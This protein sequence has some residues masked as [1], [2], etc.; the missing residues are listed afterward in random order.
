M[1]ILTLDIETGPNTAYV[2]H[3]F[4]DY[5]SLDKLQSST[6]MLTWSAKFLG[7]KEVHYREI[8]DPSFLLDLYLL[9]EEADAVVTF[10][11][12]NFD[13]KHINR[14]FVEAGFKPV[15]PCASID[16]YKAVKQNFKFP[17]NKLDY[18]AQ[19]LLGIRKL[20]T[21]GM[22]LWTA[23]LDGCPKARNKMRR[24]NIRDV[25]ITERLYRKLRPWIKN[26][27]YSADFEVDFGDTKHTCPV[28][29]SKTATE[30]RPRRTRC[31]AI[32][33]MNCNSC[34]HWFDGARRK[35]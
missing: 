4:G 30:Y 8:T 5:V 35:I 6:Q 11:G 27:P 18:V 9:L 12:D 29:A 3:L 15:R 7:D 20:D 34:G 33:Q 21:G 26:H 13:M 2:W 1:K 23:F 24:Y 31:F 14:E 25:R 17:S 22:G 19:R 10:N 28:C 32:Q 16:L